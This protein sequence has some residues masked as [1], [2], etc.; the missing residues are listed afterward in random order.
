M[1]AMSSPERSAPT[2]S[3]K[4]R[5]WHRRALLIAAI[6]ALILVATAAARLAI[7]WPFTP[8]KMTAELASA[9]SGRIQIHSFRVKYFPPGCVLEG[10]E[11]RQSADPGRPPPS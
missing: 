5:H 3:G 2:Q 11:L 6:V 10:L 8:A 1:S 7:N 4:K 9:T